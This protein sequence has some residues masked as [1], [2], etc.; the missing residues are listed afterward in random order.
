VQVLL[1]DLLW[2]CACLVI[3]AYLGYPVII[4]CLSRLFGRPNSIHAAADHELPTVSMLIVAHNEEAV[5][6]ERLENALAMGYPAGK[7]E[8]VVA[9]DGSTDATPDI[10]RRYEARG[11]LFLDY[12]QRRGKAAVINAAVEE[13]KGDIVLLSDANTSIDPSAGR[14]ITR[15]FQDPAVGVVCG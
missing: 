14:N 4:W 5:I 2:I 15:W 11:V 13:L 12:A 1:Q 7:L 10:V 6:T 8:I 3:Y 9:S